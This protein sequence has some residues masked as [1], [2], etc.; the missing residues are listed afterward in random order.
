LEVSAQTITVFIR[1]K[2]KTLFWI[3]TWGCRDSGSEPTEA[4]NS[5]Q[6]TSPWYITNRQPRIAVGWHAIDTEVFFHSRLEN[7]HKPD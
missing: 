2:L 3:T 1:L 5:T 4:A 7:Q 6:N